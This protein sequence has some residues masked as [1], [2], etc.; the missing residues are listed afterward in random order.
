[1]LAMRAASLAMSIACI[2]MTSQALR[3][4]AV[5]GTLVTGEN[6]AF[7]IWLPSKQRPDGEYTNGI[8]ISLSRAMAPL[9]GRLVP[10]AAPC[11]GHEAIGARCLT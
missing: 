3:A 7:D 10:S 9:W 1:M 6:D 2:A 4:Q 8:R 11:T 5:P